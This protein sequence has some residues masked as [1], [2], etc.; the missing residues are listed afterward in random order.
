MEYHH[1]AAY[2]QEVAE[3][4]KM[5]PDVDFDQEWILVDVQGWSDYEE[6]ATYWLLDHIP[7][8]TLYQLDNVMVGSREPR[9]EDKFDT[10]LEDWFELTSEIDAANSRQQT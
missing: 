4:K 3:L 5:F 2:L 7:S 9:W 10:N 1:Q 6:G 8:D